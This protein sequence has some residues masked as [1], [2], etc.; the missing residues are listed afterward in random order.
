MLERERQRLCDFTYIRN[1]V[2]LGFGDEIL[3]KTKKAEA[4]KEKL[5]K[6]NPIKI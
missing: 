6:L 3:Y 5:D 2:T 1:Q 4:M